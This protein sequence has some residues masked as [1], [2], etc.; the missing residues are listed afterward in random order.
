M[1][2]M[3][4]LIGLI[5]E[6]TTDIRFLKTV[7]FRSFQELS[8][9]C[10]CQ[11]DIYDIQEVMAYGKTFNEKMLAASKNGI[12]VYGISILCIHADSDARTI[13]D[14]MDYKFQ[15]FL[16]E[17]EE[18]PDIEYCKNIVP[19][20]PIQM[21]E[22]WMLADKDLFKELIDAPG[23][24]DV[25][26]GIEKLPEAYADPKATIEEAIRRAS[27][28]KPKRKR[29]QIQI[30]DLYEL[31]GNRIGLDKLRAIPSFQHFENEVLRVFTE[32]NLM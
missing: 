19:T 11:F 23:M 8:W 6:G 4:L 12:D 24:R 28:G 16:E 9:R 14:V 31:L 3:Q 29:D 27:A 21:I 10:K 15:P 22:S 2:L 7:I 30:S 5:T 17:L 25:D 32:M 26:L 13:N 1:G 18:L 20:I